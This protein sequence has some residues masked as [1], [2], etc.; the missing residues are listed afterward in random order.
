MVYQNNAAVD[1]VG[2]GLMVKG[3]FKVWESILLVAGVVLLVTFAMV[4]EFAM[5]EI[6]MKIP[7]VCLMILAAA[8]F[9]RP[10]WLAANWQR[11]S[12]YKPLSVVVS[13]VLPIW[14]GRT[15]H[16]NVTLKFG[17][18]KNQYEK[19]V[20]YGILF[21]PS[22]E[23]KQYEALVDPDRPDEFVIMPAGQANAVTFA[24]VGVLVEIALTM[25]LAA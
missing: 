15:I 5:P 23:G 7:I 13:D 8:F 21:M 11:L 25:W 3:A 12:R 16:R 6:S 17:K 1:G 20:C 19:T 18:K 14:A 4:R 24:A 10:I 22:V 2:G 9:P